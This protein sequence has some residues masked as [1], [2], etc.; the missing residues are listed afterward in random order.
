M[1]RDPHEKRRLRPLKA[2]EL[3]RVHGGNDTEITSERGGSDDE[4]T[5]A[6]KLLSYV[7]AT[8]NAQIV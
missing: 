6:Q 7:Y 8:D 5:R 2:A 4:S 3:R 1:N